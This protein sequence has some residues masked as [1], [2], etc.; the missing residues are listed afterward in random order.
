MV[1]SGRKFFPWV[2][3]LNYVYPSSLNLGVPPS[4]LLAIQWQEDLN[5]SGPQPPSMCHL[6]LLFFFFLWWVEPQRP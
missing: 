1:F 5:V 6:L 3:L 2:W 4:G